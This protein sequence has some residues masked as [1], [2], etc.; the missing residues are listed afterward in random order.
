MLE[1]LHILTFF[2]WI[3]LA[4]LA[5]SQKDHRP[6]ARFLWGLCAV[7]F[8]LCVYILYLDLVWSKTVTAPIRIDLLFLI[9]LGTVGYIV[10]GVWGIRKQGR[11]PKIASVL[12]LVFSVPTLL[13]FAHGMWQSGKDMTRLDAR[14]SLIFEAQFRNPET[15]K[16]FFGNI[17]GKNDPRAG[18]FRAEDP[19]S[20]TSRVIVND[21]GHFWLMFKCLAKVECIY[22]QADLGPTRPS[23]TFR[24]QTA[25]GPLDVIV[26]AWTQDRLSL[27]LP[28]GRR[29]TFV[30]APVSYNEMVSVPGKVSF[31]GS[32]SQT[33]IERDYVYL[34]QMWLWQSDDR[35]VAY[36]VRQNARCGSIND[37]V[38]ASA[39]KGKPLSGQIDFTSIAG[40][41]K[42]EAFRIHA[43]AA[44]SD[45]I[46][47]QI[48]YNGRPLETVTLSRGAILLSPIYESAPLTDFEST[49]DWLKTVSMGYSMPWKAECPSNN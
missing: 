9:P 24:A 17:D 29:D 38:F 37:F 22:L 35:W 31:R 15:F 18:H 7:T 45:R 41:R 16:S 20:W 28:Q 21:Q 49:T 5:G 36:Y 6:A 12:L 44:A 27:I 23:A 13:V 8:L 48:F 1:Y 2:S 11:L 43:P 10:V 46:D 25:S 14:S 19:K 47:A 30:R 40:D 4:L 42:T 26:T 33:R 39:Y 3:P 32:Y 34:V